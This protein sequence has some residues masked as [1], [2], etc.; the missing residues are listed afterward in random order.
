MLEA[1]WSF[2]H[3]GHYCDLIRTELEGLFRDSI[4]RFQWNTGY[5][6]GPTF[7]NLNMLDFRR[8]PRIPQWGPLTV[9]VL[10]NFGIVLGSLENGPEHWPGVNHS[11]C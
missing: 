5:W 11:C 3:D 2:L 9:T 6:K 1:I 4:I 10:V 8:V 7:L